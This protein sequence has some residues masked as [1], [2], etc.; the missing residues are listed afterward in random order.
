MKDSCNIYCSFQP[1]LFGVIYLIIRRLDISISRFLSFFIESENIICMPHPQSQ[2][3]VHC[4]FDWNVVCV[5]MKNL[6]DIIAKIKNK[7]ISQ[8]ESNLLDVYMPFFYAKFSFINLYTVIFW[9]STRP[10]N[11]I[12]RWYTGRKWRIPMARN[13]KRSRGQIKAYDMGQGEGPIV[14]LQ[15]C[16]G[17]E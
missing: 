2:S 9:P 8:N 15:W 16:S 3:I 11:A 7:Y 13:Q 10:K 6:F 14:T 5:S 4:Y 17:R 12:P 1:I